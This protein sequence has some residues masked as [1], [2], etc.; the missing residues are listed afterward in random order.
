MD[1]R[2]LVRRIAVPVNAHQLTACSPRSTSYF[3][4]LFLGPVISGT[5]AAR[6]VGRRKV[7]TTTDTLSSR[8][9]GWRTFSCICTALQ[10]LVLIL[11][12]VACPATRCDRISAREATDAAA[13]IA[14]ASQ[15]DEQE[16]KEQAYIQQLKRD[17]QHVERGAPTPLLIEEP[18]LAPVN[19]GRPSRQAWKPWQ[20]IWPRWRPG[21]RDLVAPWTKF[22]N[23][24]IFWAGLMVAG[25]ANLLLLWCVR[26]RLLAHRVG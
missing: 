10:G 3:M 14:S 26:L 11:L 21:L 9:Y 17:V 12:V 7:E 24:I 1:G 25:P 20:P 2:V 23:P 8:S 18:V 22:F 5:A 13:K 4:N 16:V 15:S 19:R 6:C